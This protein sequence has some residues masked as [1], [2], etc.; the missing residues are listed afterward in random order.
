MNFIP[1]I[2]IINRLFHPKYKFVF[3]ESI[4]CRA[5]YEQTME[6]LFESVLAYYKAY[7]GIIC[8]DSRSEMYDKIHRLNLGITHKIQ[9][10]KEIDVVIK[11]HNGDLIDKEQ[12]VFVSGYDVL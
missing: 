5:G 3:L 4:Y 7:S 11:T 9:G 2:P 10:E 8:L 6:S 12:P 1:N